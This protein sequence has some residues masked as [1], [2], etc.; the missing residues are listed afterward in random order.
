MAYIDWRDTADSSLDLGAP[1]SRSI[2]GDP[3]A[4]FLDG[5]YSVDRDGPLVVAK[6][7][8]GASHCERIIF[9]PISTV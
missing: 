7:Y 1:I 4:D 5:R 9:E 2:S 6:D 3:I 8:L